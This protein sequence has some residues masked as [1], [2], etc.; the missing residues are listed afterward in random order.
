MSK[1]LTPV[2]PTNILCVGL[3]YMRH[4]EEGAKKR[5]QELPENPVIFMKPTTSANHPGAPIHIPKIVHGEKL[6][7]E[8]ALLCAC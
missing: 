1:L 2:E 8:V 6:D 7:Y 4:W 3:N 5:G